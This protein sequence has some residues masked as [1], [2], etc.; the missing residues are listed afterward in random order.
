MVFLVNLLAHSAGN[1]NLELITSKQHETKVEGIKMPTFS[2]YPDE[3]LS[4]ILFQC[5]TYWECKNI[6]FNAP[7]NQRKCMAMVVANLRGPAAN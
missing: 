4:T 2:G 7:A 6:A 3:C 5:K 1:R